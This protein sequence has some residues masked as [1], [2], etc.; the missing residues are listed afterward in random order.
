V[1]V[2]GNAAGGSGRGVKAATGAAAAIAWTA[3]ERGS[4]AAAAALVPGAGEAGGTG[5]G[6]WL[7]LVRAKAA[8]G[9]RRRYS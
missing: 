1:D 9:Q 5:W 6:R 2:P 3:R 7:L 8:T 4:K